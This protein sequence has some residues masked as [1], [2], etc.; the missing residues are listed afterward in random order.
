MKE[1][2]TTEIQPIESE[3]TELNPQQE[4]FCQLYA[5]NREFFGNGTQ[6]YIEAYDIDTSKRNAYKSAMVSAS[7]LLRNDKILK[8]IHDLMEIG[9]LNDARVDKELAFLIEQNAEFGTKLGAIREYNQLKARI[10]SKLE[11]GLD[12][13]SIE[14]VKIE[15]VKKKDDTSTTTTTEENT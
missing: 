15:I 5:T 9:I 14:G 13:D 11:V 8:R 12:S 4:L 10:K 7:R 1:I 6:A 3:N 2:R